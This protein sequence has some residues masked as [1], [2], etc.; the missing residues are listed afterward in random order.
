MKLSELRKMAALDGT[1]VGAFH[2]SFGVKQ[3][4][5]LVVDID[6]AIQRALRERLNMKLSEL[7]KGADIPAPKELV[8]D[9]DAE[10]EES[11]RKAVTTGWNG[12][13][14]AVRRHCGMAASI[15]DLLA[16]LDGLKDGKAYNPP[17]QREA[18]E[19]RAEYWRGRDDGHKALASQLMGRMES[20]ENT[21][22]N[23]QDT[24][25]AM[26]SA[27]DGRLDTL[28]E[29]IN[30]LRAAK[31]ERGWGAPATEERQALTARLRAQEEFAQT[32]R[33]VLDETRK[34]YQEQNARIAALETQ[35]DLHQQA[36]N[37]LHAR[38]ENIERGVT[39][40]AQLVPD[41]LKRVQRI[42]MS[43]ETCVRIGDLHFRKA[44]ET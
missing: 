17:S 23:A 9:I 21:L 4:A 10:G 40:T 13:L 28:Q 30:E 33:R 27:K 3:A 1:V 5:E 20:V 14:N 38:I 12:A 29:S 34:G 41:M 25:K 32:L 8:A 43:M 35:S 44:T 19:S 11:C 16:V 39:S 2:H 22:R 26:H 7:R 15:H 42:E 24:A 37:A 36:H 18:K 6:A 31:Q